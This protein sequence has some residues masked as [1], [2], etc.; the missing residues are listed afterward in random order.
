MDIVKNI[1]RPGGF[2]RKVYQHTIKIKRSY[3]KSSLHHS[4]EE[5]STEDTVPRSSIILAPAIQEYNDESDISIP[6]ESE[7]EDLTTMITYVI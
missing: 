5:S 1:K 3:R 2:R 6:T 4:T 7:G